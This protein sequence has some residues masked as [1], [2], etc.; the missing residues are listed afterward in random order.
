MSVAAYASY[1]LHPE[2]EGPDGEPG[3]F[4]EWHDKAAETAVNVQANLV[5][6]GELPERDNVILVAVREVYCGTNELH[7]G[8][9]CRFLAH[10]V[11]LY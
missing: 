6:G 2:V 9:A 10:M 4:K 11:C 8:L 7:A 5:L 3:F 1:A